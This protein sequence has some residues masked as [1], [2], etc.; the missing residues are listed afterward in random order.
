[1]QRWETTDSHWIEMLC[2][3]I[4]FLS[5]GLIF[6]LCHSSS[7][8]INSIHKGCLSS[9]YVFSFFKYFPVSSKIAVIPFKVWLL[10]LDILGSHRWVLVL[11]IAMKLFI[12]IY[13]IQWMTPRELICLLS[14]FNWVI[15]DVPRWFVD[16]FCILSEIL[17]SRRTLFQLF[18]TLT[19]VHP[20]IDSLPTLRLCS[21]RPLFLLRRYLILLLCDPPIGS[22]HWRL[23]TLPDKTDI[24]QLVLSL[25]DHLKGGRLAFIETAAAKHRLISNRPVQV[26]TRLSSILRGRVV[27]CLR[28]HT[29]FV[30]IRG[31]QL[32]ERDDT[33]VTLEVQWFSLAQDWDGRGS[34]FEVTG[35][36]SRTWLLRVVCIQN[37]KVAEFTR[38]VVSEL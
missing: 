10:F 5:R 16:W 31:Q 1:M 21:L 3:L 7:N 29:C 27:R 11:H 12:L 13:L 15:L 30:D 8:W 38:G 35:D 19:W 6:L 26:V 20:L 32:I 23:D 34:I 33:V 17:L 2:N 14:I 36:H 37:I 4:N 24:H 22:G 18:V 25:Y 28:D 9:Y